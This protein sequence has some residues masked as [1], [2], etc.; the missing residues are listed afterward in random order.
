MS[1][2]NISE[3]ADFLYSVLLLLQS[4]KKTPLSKKANFLI[5]KMDKGHVQLIHKRNTVDI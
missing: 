3:L 5:K 2:F 1:S 4:G